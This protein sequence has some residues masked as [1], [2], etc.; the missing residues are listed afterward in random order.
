MG[1]MNE[2]YTDVEETMEY[3]D[4][5][6]NYKSTAYK[7]V[8]IAGLISELENRKNDIINEWS[9]EDSHD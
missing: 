1:K 5:H 8:F 7:L 6:F 2:I 4:D 9:T 3:I